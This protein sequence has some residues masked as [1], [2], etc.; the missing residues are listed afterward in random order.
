M[1]AYSLYVIYEVGI[2]FRGELYEAYDD[3]TKTI[4]KMPETDEYYRDAQKLKVT[5]RGKQI[6][7]DTIMQDADEYRAYL[8]GN[9]HESHRDRRFYEEKRFR[10][11]TVLIVKINKLSGRRL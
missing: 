7:K 9:P 1:I 5:L 11:L 8:M 10:Y 3:K 4:K 6:K 2:M